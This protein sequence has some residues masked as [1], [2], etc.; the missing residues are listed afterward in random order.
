[1]SCS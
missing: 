1:L